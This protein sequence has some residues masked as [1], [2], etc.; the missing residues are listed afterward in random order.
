MAAEA[1]AEEAR[2]GSSQSVREAESVESSRAAAVAGAHQLLAQASVFDASPAV[3]P[4][5]A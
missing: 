3:V 2:A 4:G 1:R 5:A